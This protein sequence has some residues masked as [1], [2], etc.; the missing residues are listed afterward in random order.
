MCGDCG[1]TIDLLVDEQ[2][3]RCGWQ[4]PEMVP[5]QWQ[6]GHGAWKAVAKPDDHSER[7][8]GRGRADR[9]AIKP[10]LR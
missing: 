3:D 4:N 10:E 5:D 6:P 8:E 7:R 9:H 2:C 1:H